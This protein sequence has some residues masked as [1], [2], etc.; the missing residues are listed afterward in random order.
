VEKE[1][2]VIIFF[3]KKF[4]P[5]FLSLCL[6][7]VLLAQTNEPAPAS[8]PSTPAP[9]AAPA[10]TSKPLA[11]SGWAVIGDKAKAFGPKE[12]GGKIIFSGADFG[13]KGKS[14]AG[15][16]MKT[17]LADG[18][19]LSFKSDIQFSGVST[20]GAF[21]YGIFQK[22]SPDHTRGWLGYCFY[23]G[24]RPDMPKGNLLARL[25]E[26]NGSFDGLKDDKGVETARSLGEAISGP[27]SIKDGLYT[28][29]IDVKKVGMNMEVKSMLVSEL[30]PT[31][32]AVSYSGIDNQ[33]ATPSF[34]ALGFV[35]HEVLS[36][37]SVELSNVS[38]N[39]VGP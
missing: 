8:A 9:V 19:T 32:P 38:L 28:L 37:D 30:D 1:R 14:F 6:A 15:Y 11:I 36:V 16:F 21:R 33:P 4:Y 12:E 10:V 35:T 31:F 39:L 34:D 13:K 20:V 2:F 29:T 17:I 24:F 25:P 3:M 26:N 22:R 23:A 5:L 18:Q 27:K 7:N